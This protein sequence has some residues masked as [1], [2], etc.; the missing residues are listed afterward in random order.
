MAVLNKR[1]AL[2]RRW[3]ALKEDRA[4]WIPHWQDLSTHIKPRLGRYLVTDRNR[5]AKRHGAIYDSTATRAHRVLSAGLMAGM[6]SPARP[7]FNLTTGDDDLDDF[8]SVRVWLSAVRK[9]ILRVYAK[10]NTYRAFQSMYDEL[11]LFGTAPSLVMPKYDTVQHHTPL[12][13]GQYCLATDQYGRV[14]TLFREISMSVNETVAEFGYG[15]CTPQTRRLFDSAQGDKPVILYHAIEPRAERVYASPTPQNMPWASTYFEQGANPNEYL[16]ESGMKHF[17]CLAPRWEVTANDIYGSAPAMDALGDVK[18]LQHQQL[19]KSQA[20]DYKVKP[21]IAM[22]STFKGKEADLL[23]G[24]VSYIDANSLQHG[25]RSMWEVGLDLGELREDIMDVRNRIN[26]TFY[27]DLFLMLAGADLNTMTATEVAARHEEKL[28][29]LGPVLE[30]LHNEMLAP[31]VELTFSD[32]IEAG[33]VP[34]PPEEMQGVAVNVEFIS[35]LAQA[36]RAVGSASTDRFVSNLGIVAQFKPDVLDKFDAD[37]WVDQYSDMLGVDPELIIPDE[38]VALVRK[39]RAEAQQRAEQ[40]AAAEQMAKTA[41]SLGATPTTPGTAA[42]DILGGLMG[43]NS[44][45][46]ESYG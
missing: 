13:A 45:T 1:C 3:S 21:P 16:R 39:A 5:G 18:Q 2:Q 24:G 42:G 35:V 31:Q 25:A 32:L 43:Y 8:H 30:R 9:L 33:A 38:K 26:A 11:G 10:S 40:A 44:P 28:L 34:P 36:Q 46:A 14:N 12:T 27:A 15:R 20:I 7:W 29:M 37:Q 41:Q 17:R 19:R 4:D 23:P 6:T 22:P